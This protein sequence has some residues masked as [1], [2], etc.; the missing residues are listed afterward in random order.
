MAGTIVCDVISDGAGNSTAT[1]NAI[2]GS[3]K[4]WARISLSGTTVTINKSYNISSVTRNSTGYYS[5]SFS[6]A[7][8]DANY[9]VVGSA[10]VNTASSVFSFFELFGTGSSPY[11]SAPTTSGFVF[12]TIGSSGS[13]QDTVYSSFTVFD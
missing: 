5:V 11:Y 9:S 2:Y 6:N 4:A 13:L 7:L 12:A 1:D 3:A 8:P 10:S